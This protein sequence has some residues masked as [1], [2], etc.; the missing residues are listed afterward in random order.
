M[1]KI[2]VLVAFFLPV[3]NR[4]LKMDYLS[5]LFFSP[6]S[7]EFLS[8]AQMCKWSDGTWEKN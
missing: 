8:S 5:F 3:V 4:S 7:Q 1:T 6:Y 2:P